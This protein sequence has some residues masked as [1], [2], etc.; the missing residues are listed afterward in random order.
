MVKPQTRNK[1]KQNK[2]ALANRALELDPGAWLKFEALV[3][4]AAKMGH[5]P[6]EAT[7]AV[8]PRRSKSRSAKGTARGA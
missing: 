4:S 8:K 6:H 5:K 2:P 3:K 7:A 1:S